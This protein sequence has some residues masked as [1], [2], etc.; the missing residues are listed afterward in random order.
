MKNRE[1][2][3]QNIVRWTKTRRGAYLSGQVRQA[4][5]DLRDIRLT[6]EGRPPRPSPLIVEVIFGPVKS[7]GD[8][9]PRKL[10]ASWRS[11]HRVLWENLHEL[12]RVDHLIRFGPAE[13]EYSEEEI[14]LLCEYLNCSREEL[15]DPDYRPP[16][17][18]R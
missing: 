18:R 14:S 16:R 9:S 1:I 3:D 5:Q 2:I 17:G 12:A 11:K 7:W 4:A 6:L 10:F 8:E 15:L 13:V